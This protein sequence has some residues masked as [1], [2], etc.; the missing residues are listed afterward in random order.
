[1]GT[2]AEEIKSWFDEA[3]LKGKTHMIVA[4]DTWDHEDYPVFC[5]SP[6]E[7]LRQ[8]AAHNGRDNQRVMEVYDI[9]LGWESQSS[10]RVMNLP[11][12]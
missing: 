7:C 4:T 3:A 9:S 12:P 11:S 2:S 1:M 6:E 8:Y 5:D 10:G